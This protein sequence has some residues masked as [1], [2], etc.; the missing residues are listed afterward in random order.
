MAKEIMNIYER[1]VGG[2]R[3]VAP[4]Q[5]GKRELRSEYCLQVFRELGLSDNEINEI[6]E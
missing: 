1:I 2:V 6:L 4:I 3:N 5:M